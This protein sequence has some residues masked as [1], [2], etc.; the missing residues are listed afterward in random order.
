[1]CLRTRP[2][3]IHREGWTAPF[4]WQHVRHV[5]TD[6][7]L[8]KASAKLH[9]GRAAFAPTRPVRP[10]ASCA[11]HRVVHRGVADAQ[12]MSII[13]FCGRMAPLATWAVAIRGDRSVSPS[14]VGRWAHR[15]SHT[16]SVLKNAEGR[17][18]PRPESKVI[19]RELMDDC[20]WSQISRGKRI[21][22]V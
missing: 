19:G 16:G 8:V 20:R 11:S 1:M 13:A 17:S 7:S 18:L 2:P 12:G 10:I 9:H 14:G 5:G 15:P 3:K 22:Q 21:Q 6:P 4:F